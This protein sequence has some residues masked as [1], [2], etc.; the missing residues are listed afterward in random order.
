MSFIL[1]AVYWWSGI[2]A[3]PLTM[4]FVFSEPISYGRTTDRYIT[5]EAGHLSFPKSAIVT[6]LTKHAAVHASGREMWLAEVCN[7]LQWSTWTLCVF[8]GVWYVL[9]CTLYP[10]YIYTC[11]CSCTYMFVCVIPKWTH[12]TRF[13]HW[14]CMDVQ[15]VGMGLIHMKITCQFINRNASKCWDRNQVCPHG[16]LHSLRSGHAVI[17]N[18]TTLHTSIQCNARAI[19]V[20]W[21]I[22]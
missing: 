21:T 13:V 19:V 3:I 5:Q 20:L 14:M 11:T 9:Y 15:W 1:C 12:K 7:Y 10:L 4:C 8:Y 18:A 17:R 22:L 2:W 16:G 6:V